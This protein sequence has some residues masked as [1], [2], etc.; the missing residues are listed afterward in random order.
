MPNNIQSLSRACQHKISLAQ[1][2]L[3]T[4]AALKELIENALDAGAT[5][6]DVCIKGPSALDLLQVMD[7]GSGIEARDFPF[8]CK[9]SYTSKLSSFEELG[10]V[11]TLGFRGEALASLCLLGHL[12]LITKTA[13]ARTGSCI[14]FDHMGNVIEIETAAR[15]RG[16]TVMV[17]DLFE[18]FPVRRESQKKATKREITRIVDLIQRFALISNGVRFALS[19]D[20]KRILKTQ[21][22]GSL[23]DSIAQ[24]FST[25]T[26][27]SLIPVDTYQMQDFDKARITG[28]VSKP[29]KTCARSA[30]DRQYI[31]FRNRPI[32]LRK[33]CSLATRIY[34]KQVGQHSFPLLFL[35]IELED[36]TFDINIATDKRQLF[37]H[38]ADR[39]LE[40]CTAYFC[41]LWKV[42]EYI[43]IPECSNQRGIQNELKGN[44]DHKQTIVSDNLIQ[45]LEIDRFHRMSQD[46]TTSCT[47]NFVRNEQQ[48][49]PI[50]DNNRDD[51]NNQTSKSVITTNETSILDMYSWKPLAVKRQS[52][53]SLLQYAKRK[54]RESVDACNADTVGNI[55]KNQLPSEE[56]PLSKTQI[57]EINSDTEVQPI[58]MSSSVETRNRVSFLHTLFAL[59]DENHGQEPNDHDAEMELRQVLHKDDFLSMQIIG[60]FNQGFIIAKWCGH[61]F[62]VDQHA[63]DERYNFEYLHKDQGELPCQP[64]IQP[65]T[66]HL[67]AEEEW[68][69]INHLDWIEPWGFRFSVDMDKMPGN[70][71]SLLQVPFHEKTTFGTDDVLEMIHQLRNRE[72]ISKQRRYPFIGMF[73]S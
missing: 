41:E 64:L 9:P 47:E 73:L 67:S 61:L 16:T 49:K 48:T 13:E 19:I 30:A 6:I 29:E 31:F 59:K 24:L 36:G 26:V 35:H 2:V 7:N 17:T 52:G 71:I 38:D 23:L 53:K 18:S 40:A 8:V 55:P 45:H 5:Q 15:E 10:D 4:T 72:A 51:Q 21:G 60:Q 3:D 28:F 14:S 50:E 27:A 66:M 11:R 25:M 32:E 1:A 58:Q 37:I 33:L 69:L 56:V 43:S 44:L 22:H 46:S 63:A 62:I 12:K 70:R 65:L 68:L 42:K 39:L 34:Q 57:D 20:G 54:R